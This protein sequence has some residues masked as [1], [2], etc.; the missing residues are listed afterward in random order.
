MNIL[1]TKRIRRFLAMALA[2][3]A[4]FVATTGAAQAQVPVLQ[5]NTPYKLK[6]AHSGQVLNVPNASNAENLPLVTYFDVNGFKNDDFKFIKI[7]G[8]FPANSYVIEAGK[9]VFGKPLYV[10]PQIGKIGAPVVQ[11][12]ELGAFSAWQL[13]PGQIA[14]HVE[15]VHLQSGL[16]MNVAGASHN[17]GT[18]VIVWPSSKV[19]LNDD[20]RILPAT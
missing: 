3:S 5:P 17:P 13:K 12:R 16:A 6:F 19:H 10:I 11:D 2:G 20:V 7:G 8:S 9:N 15:I 4:A 14:G 1:N 18:P